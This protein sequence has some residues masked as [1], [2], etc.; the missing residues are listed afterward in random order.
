MEA[1]V[2]GQPVPVDGER[3]VAFVTLRDNATVTEHELK[4]HLAKRLADIK[5][6]ERVHLVSSLLKTAGGKINR[7]QLKDLAAVA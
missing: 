6:P 3:V 4:E 1:V 7:R 2:V 5:V